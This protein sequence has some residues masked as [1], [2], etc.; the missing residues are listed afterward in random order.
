MQELYNLQFRR[1]LHFLSSSFV[2]QCVVAMCSPMVDSPST[3]HEHLKSLLRSPEK[4]IQKKLHKYVTLLVH[5]AQR[6][7]VQM[8]SRAVFGAPPQHASGMRQDL[9]RGFR[10]CRT[11]STNWLQIWEKNKYSFLRYNSLNGVLNP[12]GNI[13]HFN[14]VLKNIISHI[15]DDTLALIIGDININLMSEDNDKPYITRGIKDR[16]ELNKST[17][18]I[19]RNKTSQAIK[20]SQEHYY[21]EMEKSSPANQSILLYNISLKEIQTSIQNLKAPALE[22]VFN[23]A[24]KSGV[25]PYNN[26]MPCGIF[27]DLNKAFDTVNHE[28]LIDKLE[29]YGIRGKALDLF[30]SYLEN[31]K[32]LSS[33]STFFI[34]FINDLPNCCSLDNV[35]VFAD[36]TTIFFPA[37][38]IQEIINT[39]IISKQ[40]IIHL[41]IQELNMVLQLYTLLAANSIKNKG[42][43][44]CLYVCMYV[45]LSVCLIHS[46]P[47]AHYE[48]ASTR[49]YLYGRTETIRSCS[50]ASSEFCQTMLNEEA[51][52]HQKVAS[53]KTAIDSHK[54]YA[55]DAVNGLGVDRHLLGLK[56][57]AIEAGMDVPTL[58]MD[59]GYIRSSHMRVSSSQVPARCEA[60]MCY[61]PLVPDGYGCC[62]N[63]RANS[64]F[65]GTS[66]C[67]SSPETD[68]ATF[69]AAL[70]QSFMDMHDALLLD[71]GLKSKL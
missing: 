16:T 52:P 53:L 69:R 24:L 71:G 48:S 44:I 34:L 59:V 36:D 43:S 12:K 21:N 7:A 31:R 9:T 58:F 62:Y 57:A 47:G 22:K 63:P 32:Q 65:I 61:G 33:S 14:D 51:T 30:R 41:F 29:H 37:N 4:V 46:E 10:F 50:E 49:K 42:L 56:L 2:R 19:F 26:N 45:F 23:L 20:R 5:S 68:S 8:T 3:T 60:F 67:N 39:E 17:W 15:N 54:S 1:I 35:R 38:N 25:Y 11:A 40:F 18:K 6:S 55:R 66:A 27:L 28:I 70:E 64:I 13:E